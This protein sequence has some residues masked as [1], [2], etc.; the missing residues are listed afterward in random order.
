MIS[1]HAE[2]LAQRVERGSGWRLGKTL[3]RGQYGTAYLVSRGEKLEEA[4]EQAVAK[5]VPLEGLPEKEQELAFQEVELLR[6]LRHDHI[7]AHRDNFLTD[8]KLELVI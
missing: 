5:I 2:H 8:E 4:A 1:E 7:V 6:K 3:G